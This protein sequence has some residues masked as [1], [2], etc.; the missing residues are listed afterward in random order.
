MRKKIT[1][2]ARNCKR[3]GK[4]LLTASHSIHG[5]D[6]GKEEFGIVCTSC[7][8]QKEYTSLLHSM[9]KAIQTKWIERGYPNHG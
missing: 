7:T 9:G 1:L 2:L 8:T 5:L 3:C 4:E 6:K